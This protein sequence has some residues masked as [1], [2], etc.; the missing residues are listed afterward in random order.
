MDLCFPHHENEIAQSE[1]LTGK[2]M[3]NYWIHNNYVVV[4]GQKMSKS[5][6]NFTTV[7][8]ALEEY[9]S[10]ELRMFFLQ[11]NYRNV[12]DY[13]KSALEQA[14]ATLA[15]IQNTLDNLYHI[16]RLRKGNTLNPSVT[17]LCSDLNK[18]FK[19]T[20][21]NDVDTANAIGL[22]VGF[23]KDINEKLDRNELNSNEAGV[24]LDIIKMY[25]DVL[26]L[27]LKPELLV[28]PIEIEEA[29]QEREELKKQAKSAQTKEE[30]VMFFQKA[31]RIR[32]W[33]SE[34]GVLIEDTAN[35]PRWKLKR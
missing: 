8:D 20:M 15:R 32:D 24:I 2:P 1:A 30:K 14:R 7:K 35:G 27:Q 16:K 17:A 4:D 19:E 5:L 25:G 22:L 31:D 28:A 33:L 23:T 13:K 9:T 34:N 12:L 6:G 26:G 29:V 11:V 21:D 3:A 10:N 18:R